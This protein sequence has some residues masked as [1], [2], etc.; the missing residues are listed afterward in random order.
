MYGP[1]FAVN[2]INPESLS[3]RIQNILSNKLPSPIDLV[4]GL[5]N[6][7]TEKFDYLLD[8]KLLDAGA[9]VGCLDIEGAVRELKRICG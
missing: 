2:K 6:K 1:V 8:E 9:S 7:G 3:E 5:E 4:R